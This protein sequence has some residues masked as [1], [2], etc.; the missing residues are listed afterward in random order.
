MFICQIITL[1]FCNLNWDIQSYSDFDRFIN[2]KMNTFPNNFLPVIRIP[3]DSLEKMHCFHYD[4][5]LKAH[6]LEKKQ[7][8]RYGNSE[9]DAKQQSLAVACKV[10]YTLLLSWVMAM[11]WMWS[12]V[13]KTPAPMPEKVDDNIAESAFS[14]FNNTK[15]NFCK[16][17]AT[18]DI[19]SPTIKGGIAESLGKWQIRWTTLSYRIMIRCNELSCMQYV[20]AAGSRLSWLIT[21]N[22]RCQS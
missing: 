15:S 16:F 7:Q 22:Y 20:V 11:L 17:N 1:S 13:K 2:G 3:E 18:T 9:L 10:L 4:E 8:N 19:I 6:I 14:I 12:P 5:N 21:N